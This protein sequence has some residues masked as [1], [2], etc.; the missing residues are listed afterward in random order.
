[1]LLLLSVMLYR[2][3]KCGFYTSEGLFKIN[4]DEEK[5]KIKE[6]QCMC[7]WQTHK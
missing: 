3:L 4:V 1:M 6:T 5:Y 7:L 2:I